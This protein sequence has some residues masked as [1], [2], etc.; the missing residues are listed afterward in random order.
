M[1]SC[2]IQNI[3]EFLDSIFLFNSS[4]WD[5]DTYQLFQKFSLKER[6]REREREKERERETERQIDRQTDRQAERGEGLVLFPDNTRFW[7]HE[8][9]LKC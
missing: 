7:I 1:A 2:V 8:S 6:E 4:S 5:Y 9:T 3:Y